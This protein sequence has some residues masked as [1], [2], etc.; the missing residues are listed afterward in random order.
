MCDI[1]SPS[2]RDFN[3]SL[4]A[5]PIETLPSEPVKYGILTRTT[6]VKGLKKLEY[7]Y[8]PTLDF[9]F[10]DLVLDDQGLEDVSI[11]QEYMFLKRLFLSRNFIDD[12]SSLNGLE[13]L[14]YLDVSHNLLTKVLDF[15]PLVTLSYADYS[16]NNVTQMT[17]LK[18]FWQLIHLDLSHN[19]I[20]TVAG[21]SELQF[22]KFLDLS[23]NRIKRIVDGDLPLCLVEIRLANNSLKHIPSFDDPSNACKV[24]DVSQ[25]KLKSLI[26]FKNAKRLT[27]LYVHNNRIAEVAELEY[28]TGIET[29]RILNIE[30]NGMAKMNIHE[31]ILSKNTHS[32]GAEAEMMVNANEGTEF[33]RAE[34]LS[35][36]A[37]KKN[38]VRTTVF[39]CLSG[40]H[41]GESICDSRGVFMVVLVGPP[42]TRKKYLLDRALKTNGADERFYRAQIYTT[43]VVSD[44]N[45]VYKTITAE[46]FNRIAISGRFLY[47]FQYL[48]HSYGLG[49]D[50]VAKCARENKI[51]ITFANLESGLILKIRG[52]NPTLV[53]VLPENLEAY[54]NNIR[55]SMLALEEGN[56]LPNASS[57]I[58]PKLT[59]VTMMN[60]DSSPSQSYSELYGSMVLN[61][62]TDSVVEPSDDKKSSE[63]TLKLL[64]S[65]IAS[66]QS[67]STINVPSDENSSLE[68]KSSFVKISCD[69]TSGPFFAC[70]STTSGSSYHENSIVYDVSGNVS[71]G[72]SRENADSVLDEYS[73]I[74]KDVFVI[75]INECVNNVHVCHDLYK[76][77]TDLFHSMASTS[78]H[79][80]IRPPQLK[81]YG[82]EKKLFENPQKK[83]SLTQKFTSTTFLH[84][85]EL[86]FFNIQK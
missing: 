18:E 84:Y 41:T 75:L 55:Q 37:A 15:K 78:S 80:R 50:Q 62:M 19:A 16:F 81:I 35:V 30:M 69:K 34:T 3:Q 9:N 24:F 29:L 52:L 73:A 5:I 68:N 1:G 47:T 6:L 42:N 27:E 10:S 45:L 39:D 48:G 58:Q 38:A 51:L 53:L 49:E 23:N 67:D 72:T 13:E 12:L 40:M 46:V 61:K 57:E 20:E 28:L 56:L 21:I 77:T 22:L 36:L 32:S 26:Y 33:N 17:D 43:K 54:E 64:S 74:S 76:K 79:P 8:R 31:R 25:N 63:K 65:K 71:K 60:E 2:E 66:D 70:P 7:R 86:F 85:Q 59:S 11:I 14:E 83:L 44:D 4:Y 82:F